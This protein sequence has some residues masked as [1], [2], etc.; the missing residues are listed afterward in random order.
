LKRIVDPS[1]VL[2]AHTQA[3]VFEDRDKVL[4]AVVGPTFMSNVAMR[5]LA[6]K[7]DVARRSFRGRS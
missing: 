2:I 7:T 3:E 4:V 5:Q 1:P 6:R